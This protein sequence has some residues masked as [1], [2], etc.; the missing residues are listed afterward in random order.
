[1]FVKWTVPQGKNMKNISTQTRRKNKTPSR[2]INVWYII[3]RFT[4][5]ICSRYYLIRVYK[6]KTVMELEHLMK[7]LNVNSICMLLDFDNMNTNN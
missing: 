4:R 5:L 7:S 1:M 3:F 2:F 6:K